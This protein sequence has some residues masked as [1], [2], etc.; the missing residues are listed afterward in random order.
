[1]NLNKPNYQGS[2]LLTIQEYLDETKSKFENSGI[3]SARLDSLILLEY[4]CEKPR[5]WLLAHQDHQIPATE[6]K[7]LQALLKRRMLREPIAYIVGHSDFFG[8]EL[9]VSNSTLIPR[10]E[11]EDLVVAVMSESPVEAKLLEIGTGSG[12]IALAVRT[13]RPDI[14]IVASDFSAKV[15]EIAQANAA[16][17]SIDDIVFRISNLMDDIDGLY[18][19][20][21]ANLPYLD[22]N[23]FNHQHEISYEP[24]TALY[25]ADAGLSHYKKLIKQISI[26]EQLIDGGKIII[27]LEPNQRD[28]L[29][30]FAN[31][32][33]F[34]E[35]KKP[36]LNKFTLVLQKKK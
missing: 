29:I 24:K 11:T 14:R 5:S 22:F 9:N 28:G 10:P 35:L 15:I 20:I 18:D 30:Q 21:V 27:E 26:K 33:G 4:V 7:R 25:S 6:A 2:N 36:N 13:N 8:L 23:T 19:V 17:H 12:A 16:K 3:K 1:M 34:K 32:F 31:G